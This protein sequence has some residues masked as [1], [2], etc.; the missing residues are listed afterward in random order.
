MVRRVKRLWGLRVLSFVHYA[1]WGVGLQGNPMRKTSFLLV[2][3]ENFAYFSE[4]LAN[5]LLA[6]T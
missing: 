1:C 4:A 5:Y 3:M 2:W 6:Q